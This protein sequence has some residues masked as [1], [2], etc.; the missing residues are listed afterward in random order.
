MS[1]HVG[2][3][4]LAPPVQGTRGT[5]GFA[6][7]VGDVPMDDAIKECVEALVKECEGKPEAAKD[8]FIKAAMEL[9]KDVITVATCGEGH[10]VAA[11]GKA[12][13]EAAIKEGAEITVKGGILFT[14]YYAGY[15]LEKPLAKG[16][17]F[18]VK[19]G[20]PLMTLSASCALGEALAGVDV[21]ER[22]QITLATRSASS[23]VAETQF[24]SEKGTSLVTCEE[25]EKAVAEIAMKK[26]AQV[27]ANEGIKMAALKKAVAEVATKVG[28]EFADLKSAIDDAVAT[29]NRYGLSMKAKRAYV[30]SAVS[31]KGK[32][33]H[34]DQAPDEKHLVSLRHA[35]ALPSVA[36]HHII[37]NRVRKVFQTIVEKF[38]VMNAQYFAHRNFERL[39]QD[40][41]IS[42]DAFASPFPPDDDEFILTTAID[43][44]K[45][46]VRSDKIAKQFDEAMEDLTL[47]VTKYMTDLFKLLVG[48]PSK[49]GRLDQYFVER[50]AKIQRVVKKINT[51]NVYVDE[52]LRWWLQ[53]GGNRSRYDEVH[54][55]VAEM[56]QSLASDGQSK[57][58]LWVRELYSTCKKLRGLEG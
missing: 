51:K 36:S 22:A 25:L 28:A 38:L 54:G 15:K 23:T 33:R 35:P 55:R 17:E 50:A 56:F 4:L 18:V 43:A 1:Q 5:P 10:K 21:R 26:G 8:E 31:R 57:A 46:V 29:A 12:L 24:T 45:G 11:I 2:N 14:T 20:V 13:A 47:A 42:E 9:A 3:I 7:I 53:R 41:L 32:K 58:I 48:D 37:N 49:E 30:A 44:P 39:V 34:E 40:G 52:T 27:A 6:E 16:A 19:E